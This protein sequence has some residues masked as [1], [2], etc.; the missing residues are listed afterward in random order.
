M[1][2]TFTFLLA[3]LLLLQTTACASENPET[4]ETDAPA[5][6]TGV[7]ASDETVTEETEAG[8]VKDD[9]PEDLDFDGETV[10]IHIL[11]GDQGDQ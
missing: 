1:K 5:A 3:L 7:T 6:E 4:P 11:N 10:T 2:R 9:L 8:L